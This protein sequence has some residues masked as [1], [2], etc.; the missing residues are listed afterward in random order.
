MIGELPPEPAWFTDES[1]A[2][3]YDPGPPPCEGC[4]EL[5][6][7]CVCPCGECARCGAP[8]FEDGSEASE[9]CETCGRAVQ[10]ADA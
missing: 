4:G 10:G 6:A 2:P 1:L 9:L 8:L 7:Q 3:G 5:E